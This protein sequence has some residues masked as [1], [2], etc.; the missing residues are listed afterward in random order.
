MIFAQFSISDN[1]SYHSVTSTAVESAQGFIMY[2]PE[3]ETLDQ[4]LGGDMP[5]AVIGPAGPP[6]VESTTTGGCPILP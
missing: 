6:F 2:V 1:S 3:L 4:L 5:L